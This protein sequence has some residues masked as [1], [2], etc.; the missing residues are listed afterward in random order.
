MIRI[1]LSPLHTNK[2][3]C[4]KCKVVKRYGEF[5]ANPKMRSGRQSECQA[6]RNQRNKEWRLANLEKIR[7]KE[8]TRSHKKIRADKRY[9]YERKLLT[10][11]G[12]TL[13]DVDV[14]ARAQGRVCA[15]CKQVRKGRHGKL[16]VDHNHQT[17]KVRGLLCEKCNMGLGHFE[18]SPVLLARAMRYVARNDE[19]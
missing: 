4:S 9:A 7:A 8:R 13:A 14:I 3:A 6:C 16:C 17:G 10:K 12:L 5:L 19:L 11:Y 15:I 18:D 2:K 1:N